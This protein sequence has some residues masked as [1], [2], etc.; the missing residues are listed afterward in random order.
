MKKDEAYDKKYISVALL[1]LL[2]II[3]LVKGAFSS[4]SDS[5]DGTELASE[6]IATESGE[7][8]AECTDEELITL[9]K[10][11]YEAYADADLEAL[12]TIA[13]PITD[14]EKS[15]IEAFSKYYEE[16]QNITCYSSP[17]ATED[18]YLVSAVYDLKFYD[19]KTA[20]PGMEFFYVERDGKG[21]MIVNNR[22]SSYNISFRESDMDDDIYAMICSYEKSEGCTALQNEVQTRYDEALASDEDLANLVG[23][24]TLRDVVTKWHDSISSETEVASSEQNTEEVTEAKEDDSKKSSEKSDEKSGEKTS[25]KSSEASSEASSE[26]KDTGKVKTKDICKVR[27]GPGTDYEVLGMVTAGVKLKKLGTEGDWTKVEFQGSTGYIKSSLLKT[28]KKKS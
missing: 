23:N 5:Q 13:Q 10:D 14:N 3:I 12:E 22:Y 16:F 6:V 9:I 8:L 2:L 4:K 26:S 24:G 19:I 21:N 11:Y 18:S 7:A 15:Y 17:G 1:V 20:A 27:K 25:E 28:V